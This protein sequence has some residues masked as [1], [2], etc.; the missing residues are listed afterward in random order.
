VLGTSVQDNTKRAVAYTGYLL[1]AHPDRVAMLG[2]YISQD[3]YTIVLADPTG[4]YCTV[5][6]PLDNNSL[7]RRALH[8]INEPPELMIGPTI[9]RENG[10]K[11][12][13]IVADRYTVHGASVLS[14]IPSRCLPFQLS[15]ILFVFHSISRGL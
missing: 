3:G 8:H 6:L 13:P 10:G 2:L 14:S 12:N 4:T 15:S 5:P 11:A 1:V 7:L 9:K